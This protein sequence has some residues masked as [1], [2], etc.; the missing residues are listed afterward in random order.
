ME[1]SN[2]NR[3]FSIARLALLTRNH[4]LDEASVVGIGAAAILALN[5]LSI[6]VARRAFFNYGGMGMNFWIPTIFLAGIFLS[7]QAFKGMHDGKA[8]T[9]WILLPATPLEKYVAAFADAVILFPLV[10][11]FAGM[12]LSALFSLLERWT[13]GPGSAVWTPFTLQAL[14]SWADYAIVAVVFLAGSATFRKASLI[15]T[16]GMAAA[17]GLAIGLVLSLGVWAFY[18]AGSADSHVSIFG[19]AGRGFSI[20]GKGFDVSDAAQRLISTGIDIARYAIL[21]AF[22]ILFG[23]AR[24]AEKESRDEVQ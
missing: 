22:A 15:K 3:R 18:K 9:E 13:G 17:Y 20:M 12:A 23:A 1:A 5:L 2:L 19:G 7:A 11:A 14:R 8:G 21:P 6:L 24:V 10:A 4:L 16:A